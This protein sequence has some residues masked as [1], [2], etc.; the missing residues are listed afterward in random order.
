M[1]VNAK[2]NHLQGVDWNAINDDERPPFSSTMG[3]ER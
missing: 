2:A 1:G 3:I